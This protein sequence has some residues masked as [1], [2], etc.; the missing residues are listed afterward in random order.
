MGPACRSFY[1]VPSAIT[2][3]IGIKLTTGV[4]AKSITVAL[5]LG[6]MRRCSALLN[7]FSEA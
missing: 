1:K 5:L 4:F 3:K 2:I 6:G 7:M